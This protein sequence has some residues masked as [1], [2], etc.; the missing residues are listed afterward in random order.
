LD[1]SHFV[2]GLYVMSV[3]NGSENIVKTFI[4]DH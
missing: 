2:E 3:H 1:M 4:V